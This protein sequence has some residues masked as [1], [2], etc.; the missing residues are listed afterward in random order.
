MQ[1]KR[2]HESTGS[3]G[4]EATI[5]ASSKAAAYQAIILVAGP[6][7]TSSSF[8]FTLLEQVGSEPKVVDVAGLMLTLG[9]SVALPITWGRWL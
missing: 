6:L 9:N 8:L 5:T 3:R 4:R 2:W 1:D 7:P